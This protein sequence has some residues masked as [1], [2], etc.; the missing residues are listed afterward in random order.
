M[1][2]SA[3]FAGI[4]VSWKHSKCASLK[5]V[6][7]TCR[8]ERWLQNNAHQLQHANPGT[9]S[10]EGCTATNTAAEVEA[11]DSAASN[12]FMTRSSSADVH[13]ALTSTATASNGADMLGAAGGL[14]GGASPPHPQPPSQPR[15]LSAD[16]P[17]AA[18]HSAAVCSPSE[19]PSP[20]YNSISSSSNSSARVLVPLSGGVDS[21]LLAALVDRAL[22]PHEPIDLV[23]V[24][25]AGARLL[26]AIS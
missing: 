26:L 13:A 6:A 15:T 16:A 8:Y 21:T 22:P 3:K 25:F 14:E 1:H 24:C 17:N 10:Q 9:G 20:A 11:Y 4:A 23:N 18:A 12:D 7:C 5:V 2:L 19:H